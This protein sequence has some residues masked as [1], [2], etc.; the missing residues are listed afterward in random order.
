M[1]LESIMLRIYMGFRKMVTITL[2]AAAKSLQS[3]P[4]LC[5]PRDGSPGSPIPRILQARTLEWVAISFSNAWEWK[6]KG[7]SLSRVW[8]LATPWT[9]AYQAPLPMGFSR[10]EYWS[11]LPLSSLT[12]Y[13]LG[14]L[15]QDRQTIACVGEDRKNW[16][17]CTLLV[18]FENGTTNL[19]DSLAA[20]QNVKYRLIMWFSNSIHWYLL[21][22]NENTCPY[23]PVQEFSQQPCS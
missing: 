17:H 1:N 11:G 21:K 20:S 6:V 15:K 12:S 18:G 8:L 22:I 7:K 23:K 14:L 16:K 5:D 9:A 13:P 10:Q 19:E 2:Y 3:C 4:A